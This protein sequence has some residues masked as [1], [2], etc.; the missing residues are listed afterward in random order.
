MSTQRLNVLGHSINVATASNLYGSGLDVFFR[1]RSVAIIG[2]TEKTGHVGRAIVWNLLSTP[3][4]GIIYPVNPKRSS[5]L[6]VRSYPSI[7]SV[8][9]PVDL[10]II[11]TPAESVPAIIQECSSAGVRGAI[12][13]SAGFRETGEHG[14]ELEARILSAAR[15][16]KLRILGPNCLG[17]MCPIS[18]LNATFAKGMA[19]R[20]TVAVISQSGAIC[21][22][23]LDWSKRERVG[24]SALLST[25]SMIDIGWGALIDYLAADP[26]TRSIVIYMESIGDARSF[27]SA[28]REAALSK[29]I[30]IIKGGRTEL[31]ARAAASHTGSLTGSDAVL[32]AAFRRVGL[33]RMNELSEVFQMIEVLAHQPLPRGPRLTIV[34]NAGGPAVLA[35]DALIQ[36]G[37]ELAATSTETAQLLNSVLPPH[38]SHANP[39]D[40]IG[41]AGPERYER[42]LEI[43]TNDAESDGLLVVMTPQ[44]MTD[45]TEIAEKIVRFADLK[46]RPILASWMGGD[47]SQPGR[48]ILNAAG[49]PTFSFPDAAAR[50]FA[51]M[52]RYSYALRALYETPALLTENP[53]STSKAAGL[54]EDVRRGGR[55]LLTEFESKQL[56]AMYGIETVETVWA[57]SEDAAVD[58][59][60]RLRYPVVLKLNSF[61]ITHKA[62]VGGVK[63][64]LANANAVRAAFRDIELSVTQSRGAEHFRGVTVQRMVS[65]QGYELL[66]GSTVD[67]QFGPVIVFGSGGKF[68]EVLQDRAIGF[69]PLN[70]TLAYRLIEHTRAHQ[71]LKAGRGRPA[72]PLQDLEQLLVRFSQ[73]ILEQPWIKEIDINPLLASAEGFLA[74]DARVLLYPPTTDPLQIVKPAIRPYPAQYVYK[75]R[76]ADDTTLQIRPIRPEDEPLIVK[77]HATLSEQTVYRRYFAALNLESRTRHERLTRICFIDY[78]REMALVAERNDSGSK[79]IVGVGRLIKTPQDASAE[80][81]LVVNDSFQRHGIGGELTHRLIEV[82]RD[83][84]LES[85]TASV[86][87]ENRPM[88]ELLE[89]FGFVINTQQVCEDVL[90]ATLRLTKER[91]PQG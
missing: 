36:S 29:P 4:N 71:A 81:A 49:I 5:V 88:Q 67:E 82:A 45:P 50:T 20:G 53:S 18:G 39:I 34:T 78:D 61:T 85:V 63:L 19:L 41:D 48:D 70:T 28:A 38:W 44:A 66:V 37:G 58:A 80:L 86:L 59:A 51:D 26:N 23:L 43:V 11:T 55:H 83:E 6:G 65:R 62:E 68:V 1:P 76:L 91:A 15:R 10:A 47:V 89:K 2:A 32:D 46:N 84:Q 17:V 35:T 87:L 60:E 64:W 69:P 72:V 21:T 25:G 42:T 79:E 52:W 33:L 31:A 24:F 27:L 30:L 54:I 8:P 13:I 9:E 75:L 7:A 74:L 3:F 40:L 77:F 56:L 14:L 16:S 22:A 57:A 73:M 12:I 90:K